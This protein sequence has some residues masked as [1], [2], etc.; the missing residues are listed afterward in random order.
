MT[1]VF[2]VLLF[3]LW[4]VPSLSQS[5]VNFL[6]TVHS[7]INVLEKPSEVAMI[8]CG[9]QIEVEIQLIRSL[10]ELYPTARYSLTSWNDQ[11]N[12]LFI[13]DV[14]N[15]DHSQLKRFSIALEFQSSRWLI[16]NSSNPNGA[17]NGEII[18]DILYDRE[19]TQAAEVAVLIQDKHGQLQLKMIYKMARVHSNRIIFEDFASFVNQSFTITRSHNVTSMRRKNMLGEQL[20]ITSVLTNPD[21][22]NHYF[23]FVDIEVDTVGKSGHRLAIEVLQFMNATPKIILSNSWGSYNA[24]TGKYT[25]MMA[26]LVSGEAI[27][28][29]T[30]SFMRSERVDHVEYLSI[31]LESWCRIVFRAPK[32]SYTTNVYLLPFQRAIWWAALLLFAAMTLLLLAAATGEWKMAR[33]GRDEQKPR[34]IDIVFVIFSAICNQGSSFNLNSVAGRIILISC[35][36]LVVCLFVSYSAFIVVLLQSPATNIKTAQDLLNSRMEIGAEDTVYNRYWLKVLNIP[37]MNTF[38]GW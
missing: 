3:S 10:S 17:V 38:T 33:E 36:I 28:G 14:G 26:D 19:L 35:L 4:V 6:T 23:D 12:R 2:L 16:V 27:F 5:D 20:P 30:P 11:F 8:T 32:L 29:G 34:F 24:T 7:A 9:D 25:G 31:S 21:S 13:F 18:E 1:K 37:R 22:I 15:C